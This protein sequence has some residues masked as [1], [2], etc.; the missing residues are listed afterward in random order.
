MI[1][2]MGKVFI[3]LLMVPAILE[4]GKTICSMDKERKLGKII[5]ILSGSI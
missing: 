1:K 5:L 3:L 4:N 2:L